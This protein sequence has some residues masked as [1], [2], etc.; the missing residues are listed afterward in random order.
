M[1]MPMPTIDDL[2][3]RVYR[4]Y[5]RGIESDDPR[6]HD[7]EESRRLVCVQEA[8]AR[9]CE[10]NF[11]EVPDES[12]VAIDA[13]VVPVVNALRAWR[14]FAERW[15]R[16]HPAVTLWDE[17]NPWHDAS[18]RY[19]ALKPGYV[20]RPSRRLEEWIDPVVCR[21]SAL[22]PVYLIYTYILVPGERTQICYSDFPER[23]R[24]RI[25]GLCALAEEL[26]GFHRISEDLARTP[27]PDVA[28][29]G[30]NQPMTET[31]LAD[32]L[33]SSYL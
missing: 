12:R 10:W 31:V 17:S 23:Y 25:A 21:V 22:A 32:C 20:H 30:S 14:L 15:Q 19:T 33:F 3:A 27:V 26:F 2:L 7:T 16:E 18:Y 4:H 24:G 1:S 13:E 6:H 29:F 9:S 8:A 5:P 11:Y 28:P